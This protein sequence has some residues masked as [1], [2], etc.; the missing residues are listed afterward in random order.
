MKKMLVALLALLMVLSFGACFNKENADES[1]TSSDVSNV[2]SES[3]DIWLETAEPSS[4][5]E[6]SEEETS[7]AES[8]EEE[9]AEAGNSTSDWVDIEF[10]R[11]Q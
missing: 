2:E 10:P 9:S 1:G 8:V 6:S 11:P 5:E 4:E 3:K 7:E